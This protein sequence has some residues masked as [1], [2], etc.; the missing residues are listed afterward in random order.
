ME[1]NKKIWN[2]AELVSEIGGKSIRLK[3]SSSETL[4][5]NESG[6]FFNPL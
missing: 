1:M 5:P 3:P 4:N 2:L 6:Q